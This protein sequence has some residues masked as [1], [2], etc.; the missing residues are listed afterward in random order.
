MPTSTLTSKGQTTVPKEI[1]DAL[2]LEPGTKLTWELH[3]G[4]VTL[5]RTERPAFWRWI[6]SIDTGPDDPVEAVRQARKIRGR[7]K[8]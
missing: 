2:K 1:R 8:F 7:E 4:K 3:G 5:S 6:G